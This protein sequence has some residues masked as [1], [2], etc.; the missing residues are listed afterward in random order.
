MISERTR[1][2]LARAKANGKKLGNPNL[3]ADNDSRRRQARAFAERLHPTLQAFEKQ[4]M[5]QRAIVAELN[6]LGV[7]APRG[8]EWSL[9]QL[10]RVLGRLADAG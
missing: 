6:T 3:K 7:Q 5:S 4:G 2:A 10:Q 8:G 1:A 9:V